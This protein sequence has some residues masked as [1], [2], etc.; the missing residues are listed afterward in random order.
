MTMFNISFFYSF[1]P[2]A[3]KLSLPFPSQEDAESFAREA[4]KSY[5]NV[6]A[7]LVEKNS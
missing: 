5:I 6:A 4:S 2:L 3:T 7:F 1:G